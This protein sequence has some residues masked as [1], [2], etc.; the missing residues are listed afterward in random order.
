[1]R[2]KMKNFIILYYRYFPFYY[3]CTITWFTAPCYTRLHIIFP[4][5]HN[6]AITW[7]LRQLHEFHITYNHYIIL[8]ISLQI[9][10]FFF[11]SIFQ[12]YFLITFPYPYIH[13]YFLHIF[14]YHFITY[15]LTKFTY[16]LQIS[17][18][19]SKIL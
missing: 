13:I 3:I 16:F 2:F 4:K 8:F 17:Q 19:H 5:L 10:L 6:C 18:I 14:A 9:P 12:L 7:L 11:F 1:M 15:F